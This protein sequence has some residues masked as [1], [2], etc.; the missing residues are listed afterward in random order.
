MLELGGYTD[1]VLIGEG[2]LGR[3]YRGVRTSTGGVVAIKELHDVAAASPAWHRAAREVDAMLRLKSHPYV[4]SVEEIV[5]GASGPCIVMEY[6][7]GGSLHDRMQA[8]PLSVPE[9]VLVGHHVAQALAA[10]HSVGVIHRDVKPH[11]LLVGAF[12]QVKVADFGIASVLRDTGTRTMTQAL[13]LAYASPE[14]LDGA[15]DVGPPTD[16]YSLAAT[17]GHLATGVKPSFRDRV[18]TMLPL[19]QVPAL[20]P[21]ATTLQQALATDP[22]ARPTMAEL[23][24]AF[25]HASGMLGSA[26]LTALAVGPVV[27]APGPHDGA[28]IVRPSPVTASTPTV[29]RPPRPPAPPAQQ[30]TPPP[31]PPPPTPAPTATVPAAPHQRPARSL[32]VALVAIAALLVAA[33]GV[34]LAILTRSDG[35]EADSTSLAQSDPDSSDVLGGANTLPTTTEATRVAPVTA[36]VADTVQETIA[37]TSPPTT[38][39]PVTVTVAATPAPTAVPVSPAGVSLNCN[40]CNLRSAPTTVGSDIVASLSGSMGAPVQV[41]RDDGGAWVEVTVEGKTGWLFG[42]FTWPVPDGFVLGE[43]GER[44]SLLDADGSPLGIENPTGNKVLITELGGSL[45][46]VLLPDG[47]IAYVSA[48]TPTR[49]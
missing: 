14:E 41:L 16:V 9:T 18:P 29:V 7:A 28:T 31:P 45:H 44:I 27:H 4:V 5:E 42:T 2:G 24:T 39:T 22:A 33:V 49:R 15:P 6:L 10:A 43:Q 23:V 21:L 32:V 12:G 40:I 37:P 34:G 19:A 3:V 48:S 8:G 47:T 17:L 20:Q 38:V 25:D 1:L 35:Q 36:T 13:T 46:T 26:K 30:A 11:N